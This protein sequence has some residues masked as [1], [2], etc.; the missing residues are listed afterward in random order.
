MSHAFFNMK[1]KKR[2]IHKPKFQQ[3][4]FIIYGALLIIIVFGFFFINLSNASRDHKNKFDLEKSFFSQLTSSN[5]EASKSGFFQL[6][7]ETK[8][9]LSPTPTAKQ[10]E[11]KISYTGFCLSVPVLYYHHIQRSEDAAKRQQTSLSVDVNLFDQQMKYLVD[12]GYTTI[13]AEDLV[14]ALLNKSTLNPKSVVITLDDGYID[15]YTNAF[16]IAKRYSIKLNLMIPTG[17]LNNSDYM[18]WDNLKEMVNTGLVF[19]YDHSWSHFSLP[20]GDEKKIENEV[21]LGK[22]QLEEHLGKT[23]KIFTYP[24]G[25]Y[26]N[27][28]ISVLQKNGFV[29]A[30]TTAPSF[31]QC[32]SFMMTLHRNHIG[33][34]PLSSYGL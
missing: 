33:N 11:V 14:N 22:Q 31:T 9:V 4:R 23:I 21:M 3:T 20:R 27:L 19:A 17:L 32:D 1:R 8:E 2:K 28:S 25:S 16:P 30:F 18:S 29:A 24:Y 13:S 7:K 5:D 34:A 6:R 12:H 10:K 26:N 15:A